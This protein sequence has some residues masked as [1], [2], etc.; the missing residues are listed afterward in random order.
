MKLQL[1]HDDDDAIVVHVQYTPRCYAHY[2]VGVYVSMGGYIICNVH[3]P[4]DD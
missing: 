4:L 3:R 2:N 1:S